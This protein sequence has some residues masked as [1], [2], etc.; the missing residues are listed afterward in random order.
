MS[1]LLLSY[2]FSSAVSKWDEGK[3]VWVETR[4]AIR[5]GVRMVSL[6]FESTKSVLIGEQL[7]IPSSNDTSASSPSVTS[8]TPVDL[9]EV[10]PDEDEKPIGRSAAAERPITPVRTSSTT[11][12]TPSKDKGKGRDTVAERTDEL[13]GLFVSFAFALQCVQSYMY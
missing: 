1:G 13:T 9:G 10:S 11:D 4:T 2:R 7:S 5:D 3:K 8:S 12:S 6:Q